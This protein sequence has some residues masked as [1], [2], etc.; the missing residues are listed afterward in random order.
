[1]WSQSLH[2]HCIDNHFVWPLSHIWLISLN[3]PLLWSFLLDLQ[4]CSSFLY[5]KKY[6][7][8]Y[9]LFFY[10]LVSYF[11]RVVHVH[12]LYYFIFLSLF[13]RMQT[14]CRAPCLSPVQLPGFSSYPIFTELI[15]WLVMLIISCM[16]KTLLIS[17]LDYVNLNLPFSSYLHFPPSFSWL[18]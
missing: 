2:S 9:S 1:M 3:L 12:C 14:G 16:R 6:S 4:T 17:S 18:C 13:N 8:C 7:N 11:G 15:W 5:L 10:N